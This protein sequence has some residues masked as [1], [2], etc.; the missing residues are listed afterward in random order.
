MLN[1]V[2]AMLGCFVVVAYIATI[3]VLIFFP[4]HGDNATLQVL[5]QN[6]GSLGALAGLVVGYF[7]GSSAQSREKDSALSSVVKTATDATAAS[8]SA[9]ATVVAATL[10]AEAAKTNGTPPAAPKPAAPPAA[11]PP[12]G[13]P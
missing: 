7:Y 11:P 1:F 5:V 13:K 12:G 3:Q 9:A 2:A 8:A 10:P 4:P 6:L